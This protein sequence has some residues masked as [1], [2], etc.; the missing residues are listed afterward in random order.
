[1][2]ELGG[3]ARFDNVVS[4][5]RGLLCPQGMPGEKQ[6]RKI[7]VECLA[8]TPES[9]T[10]YRLARF[11]LIWLDVE[12]MGIHVRQAQEFEAAGQNAFLSWKAVYDIR[13]AW[14]FSG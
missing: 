8:S 14:T 6:L 2:E 7:L 1:M 11:P 3:L 9:G 4:L 12:A 10:S 13:E 5:L